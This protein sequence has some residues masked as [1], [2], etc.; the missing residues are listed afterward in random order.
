MVSNASDDLPDP[1]RPVMTVSVFRGISTSIFFRLCWRA[2]C[3]VIRSSIVGYA[4]GRRNF[5]CRAGCASH[6]NCDIN[7]RMAMKCGQCGGKLRRVHRK[8]V[9]RFNYMAIYECQKCEREEFVPR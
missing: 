4:K 2:P 9:E 3:T 1:L 8:F 5:Y 7:S 6:A